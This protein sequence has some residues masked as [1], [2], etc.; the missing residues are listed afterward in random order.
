MYTTIRSIELVHSVASKLVYASSRDYDGNRE[1]RF[2]EAMGEAVEKVRHT[3]K[4]IYSV[5]YYPLP[6][7]LHTLL[8]NMCE[9]L[10]VL[11]QV[12]SYV[13]N[14]V[15]VDLNKR[16]VV[17]A[18]TIDSDTYYIC[19][20]FK[21]LCKRFSAMC[22]KQELAID[23]I[24]REL[25]PIYAYIHKAYEELIKHE[26]SYV[27]RV[28]GELQ[29]EYEYRDMERHHKTL[30]EIEAVTEKLSIRSLTIDQVKKAEKEKRMNK[31]VMIAYAGL[32]KEFVE[33]LRG[34]TEAK[35]YTRR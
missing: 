7:A 12:F 25:A 23:V 9:D 20:L 24:E 15:V 3:L 2:N 28:L 13:V 8:C 34:Y 33:V 27:R 18:L 4:C 30:A 16:E 10:K 17:R 29:K 21:A 35:V 19:L 14:S 32:Q 22:T 6:L 11:N 1:R 26:L 31:R 5:L